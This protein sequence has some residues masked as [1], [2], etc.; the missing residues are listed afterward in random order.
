MHSVT[1]GILAGA[2]RFSAVDAFHGQYRLTALRRRTEQ[3]WTR[4][5]AL[6]VPSV[7]CFP[8]LAALDADPLGPNA[9]LGATAARLAK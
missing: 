7:P 2:V 8:T 9:R 6:A 3:V 1:R 5:D 4:M